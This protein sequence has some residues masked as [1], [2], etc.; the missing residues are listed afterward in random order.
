MKIF[1]YFTLLSLFSL[2]AHASYSGHRL[3]CQFDSNPYT[4]NF[5]IEKSNLP[6][7]VV[8]IVKEQSKNYFSKNSKLNLIS[9]APITLVTSKK[10]SS[11]FTQT[12]DNKVW[13]MVEKSKP[14]SGESCYIQNRVSESSSPHWKCSKFFGYPE[15]NPHPY[16]LLS[17]YSAGLTS[18]DLVQ[19]K[20]EEGIESFKLPKNRDFDFI[21]KDK[22]YSV[23]ISAT[24]EKNP[25]YMKSFKC[26][27]NATLS[28]C[29]ESCLTYTYSAN[30]D[31]YQ[32][33][34][35]YRLNISTEH[36]QAVI[37]FKLA[38]SIHRVEAYDL[39]EEG[40][41]AALKEA[42]KSQRE[43]IKKGLAFYPFSSIAAEISKHTGKAPTEL[44]VVLY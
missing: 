25:N 22:A 44:K 20:R 37:E 4:I 38:L 7:N 36:N 23:K 42:L 1:L 14:A 24:A 6:K 26:Q 15:Q 28:I 16:F 40:L 21:Y 29:G 27:N 13:Y 2:E 11:G 9:D 41:Q 32:D 3:M 39:K 10:M 19:K 34:Q 12:I 43:N 31:Y 33:S 35:V 17:P 18:Y 30:N 8:K 5:K